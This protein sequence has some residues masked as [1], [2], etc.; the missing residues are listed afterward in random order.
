MIGQDVNSRVLVYYCQNSARENGNSSSVYKLGQRDDVVLRAVPC[1]GKIDPRYILRAFEEG[2]VA[3]C[4]LACPDGQCKLMEGNR[5]VNRRVVAV[6]EFLTEAGVNPDS[7][8]VFVPNGG[9]TEGAIVNIEK[10]IGERES[11]LQE[12]GA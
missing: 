11:A 12:A 9:G 6:R 8:E 4:I 2:A 7:V 5:R 1:S 10:Y 3:V